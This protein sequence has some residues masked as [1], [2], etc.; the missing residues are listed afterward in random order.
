[1]GLIT[2]TTDF[3]YEDNFVGLMKGVILGIAPQ[4]RI[5]DLTHGI[6]AQDVDQAAFSIFNAYPYFPSGTVHLAVVDP[7]VGSERAILAARAHDQFFIG[8]DNGLLSYVLAEAEDLEVRRVE[9]RSLFSPSISRTFHGRDIMAPAAAHLSGQGNFSKLGPP[10]G[11]YVC[12]PPLAAE[13]RPDRARGR[14]VDV[15]RFGNL[16]TNIG[17]DFFDSKNESY[18]IEAGPLIIKGLSE[19]YADRPV[20]AHLAVLGS[21]GFLEIARNRD[22][23]E[24]KPKLTL[25]TEVVATIHERK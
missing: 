9:N 21:F 19:S 5:V 6:R 15:D 11:Q 14:V 18:I 8:P 1:M 4:V 22:R 3:G 2:L 16:V 23:A 20:G 25:G 10:I 13:T 24:K 17:N 12:L 7:G